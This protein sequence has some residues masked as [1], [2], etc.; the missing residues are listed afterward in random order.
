MSLSNQYTLHNF[1]L[2]ICL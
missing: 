2:V 1:L